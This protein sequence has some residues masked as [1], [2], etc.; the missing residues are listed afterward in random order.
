M[1]LNKLNVNPEKKVHGLGERLIDWSLNKTAEAGISIIRI[2]VW[3]TNK[4]LRKYYEDYGFKYIRTEPDTVSGA[5]YIIETKELDDQ[6]I[7]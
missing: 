6:N 7:D 3:T 5:L 1:Y 4:R 2:E